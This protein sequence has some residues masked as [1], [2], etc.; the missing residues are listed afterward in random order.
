MNNSKYKVTFNQKL[1]LSQNNFL[2]KYKSVKNI[3][4][5]DNRTYYNSNSSLK[6]IS[7]T[8]NNMKFRNLLTNL[9]NNNTLLNN[10]DNKSNEKINIFKSVYPKKKKNLKLN[11]EVINSFNNQEL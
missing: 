11:D 5:N 7:L 10:E 2:P 3:K 8:K 9:S 4:L 1:S 6:Q